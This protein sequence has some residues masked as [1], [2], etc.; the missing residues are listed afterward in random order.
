MKK[1]KLLAKLKLW[2][3]V[4]DLQG[5]FNPNHIVERKD[6]SYFVYVYEDVDK[7]DFFCQVENCEWRE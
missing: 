3:D 5:L 7:P 6:D 4:D 1:G 2:F